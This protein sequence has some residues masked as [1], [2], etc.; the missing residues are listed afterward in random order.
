MPTAQSYLYNFANVEFY[1]LSYHIS[2]RI[3]DF[4]VTSSAGVVS[5]F[6]YLSDRYYNAPL[7]PGSLPLI[8]TTVTW[9]SSTTLTQNLVCRIVK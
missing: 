8:S 5:Y 9:S 4:Y 7:V 6:P 1:C 3:S 2:Q